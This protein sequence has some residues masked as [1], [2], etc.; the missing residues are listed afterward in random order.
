MLGE[1]QD[2]LFPKCQIIR[3]DGPGDIADAAQQLIFVAAVHR[4]AV[5]QQAQAARA[6][7]HPA[8]P[9]DLDWSTPAVELSDEVEAFIEVAR[10]VI[11]VD[12]SLT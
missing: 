8:Q 7:E 6:G 4:S 12:Q 5:D 1:R 10:T 11:A 9:P 3:L 2:E